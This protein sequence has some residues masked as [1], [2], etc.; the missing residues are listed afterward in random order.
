[1]NRNPSSPELSSIP[2][3]ASILNRNYDQGFTENNNSKPSMRKG[4]DPKE[5]YIPKNFTTGENKS[6]RKASDTKKYQLEELNNKVSAKSFREPSQALNSPNHASHRVGV[7]YST[8][9]E[10]N[11]YEKKYYETLGSGD[12][13]HKKHGYF[14]EFACRNKLLT[15]QYKLKRLPTSEHSRYISKPVFFTTL[16]SKNKMSESIAIDHSNVLAIS[17]QNT[18]KSAD[19]LQNFAKLDKEDY[20][21][22][23]TLRKHIKSLEKPP[24][25]TTVR[26]ESNLKINRS[27]LHKNEKIE[28][29]S[30]SIENLNKVALNFKTTLKKFNFTKPNPLTIHDHELSPNKLAS[31]SSSPKTR[32]IINAHPKKNDEK[33]Q[34]INSSKD[35]QEFVLYNTKAVVE[36]SVHN[37]E[38]LSRVD[39]NKLL[40]IAKM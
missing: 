18:I 2:K 35:L 28:L 22:S 9:I 40:N 24:G 33:L 39:P 23:P 30:P 5:H 17:K 11:P 1:M 7:I 36:A 19:T 21:H 25:L 8:S 37:Y 27:P 31:Y 20:I 12:G 26:S 38:E 3:Y 13:F 34:A 10:E 6:N 4:S 15:D 32:L 29:A 16:E 14:T